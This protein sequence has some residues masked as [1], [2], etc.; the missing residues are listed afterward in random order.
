MSSSARWGSFYLEKKEKGK[1]KEIC[2]SAEQTTQQTGGKHTQHFP[3][4]SCE[5]LSRGMSKRQDSLFPCGT[6]SRSWILLNISFLLPFTLN[7]CERKKAFVR[8]QNQ[9]S[10]RAF[11]LYL[12]AIKQRSRNKQFCRGS[13]DTASCWERPTTGRRTSSNIYA[14][15]Q[16]EPLV[17]HLGFRNSLPVASGLALSTKR[18]NP[19]WL[20]LAAWAILLSRSSRGLLG[21]LLMEYF[22]RKHAFHQV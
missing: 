22:T 15:F 13:P 10:L 14:N 18:F 9:N 7:Y 19:A 3:D 8:T 6:E 12:Q 5:A 17:F 1:R 21:H 11:R 16:E 4:V 20:G 2:L